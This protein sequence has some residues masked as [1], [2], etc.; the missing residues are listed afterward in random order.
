[1]EDD[2]AKR[3]Y[4]DPVARWFVTEAYR[5]TDTAE[6]VGA[7]GE[8]RT[9]VAWAL[10]TRRQQAVLHHP[11]AVRALVA[12]ALAEDIGPLGDLTAALVPADAHAAVEGFIKGD[13]ER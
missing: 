5:I 3:V 13:V 1:M 6:L 2:I 9:V 10:S 11:A 7:A 4:S 12:S 8:D